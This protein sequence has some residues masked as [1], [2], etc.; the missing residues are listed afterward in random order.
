[1]KGGIPIIQELT[2][3]SVNFKINSLSSPVA[4]N[5]VKIDDKGSS[6]LYVCF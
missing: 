2:S 5:T 1:M 3:P 6:T 4:N